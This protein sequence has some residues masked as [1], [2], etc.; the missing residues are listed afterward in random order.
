MKPVFGKPTKDQLAVAEAVVRDHFADKIASGVFDDWSSQIGRTL[1][2]PL[3]TLPAPL[4][5]KRYKYPRQRFNALLALRTRD[6]GVLTRRGVINLLAFAL[7]VDALIT[8]TIPQ[9]VRNDYMI[10]LLGQRFMRREVYSRTVNRYRS[11]REKT[12]VIRYGPNGPEELTRL[13]EEEVPTKE[14]CRIRRSDL[15]YLGRQVWKTLE[16]T[17]LAGGRDGTEWRALMDRVR[18][19]LA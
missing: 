6:R 3:S 11:R 2:R 9:P 18:Q 10:A 15:R 14:Y 8:P 19:R 7:V 16:K 13:I 12:G 17:L 5:M 4:A 1:S